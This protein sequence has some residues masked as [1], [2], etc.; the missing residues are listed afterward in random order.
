MGLVISNSEIQKFKDCKRSWYAQYYLQ[1]QPKEQP[2]TGATYLGTKVHAA[3][4][5]YYNPDLKCTPV[6][7]GRLLREMY[8]LDES[9]HPQDSEKLWD[10]YALA[11][12]MVYG[13]FEWL[14][15][16]GADQNL[17]VI[18]VERE[19]VVK[20]NDNISIRGRLDMTVAD[21]H[22]G[23]LLFMD[24]KTC[25]QWLTVDY[26][27]R[28]EQSKFYMMLQRLE[29]PGNSGLWCDGGIFNMLRKV[30]RTGKAVPPFYKRETIRHNTDTL[31]SMYLRTVEAAS[32][33][34]EVRADLDAG[35]DHRQVVY[36]H[37]GKDCVWKC[38]LASGLC[39]MLDDGSDWQGF[40]ENEWKLVDPYARYYEHSYLDKLDQAGIL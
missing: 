6:Q 22:S 33:I 9:A 32:E 20:L 31:N 19:I 23:S 14:A 38:P 30:K 37:P 7:V 24:H 5:A 11:D 2:T 29:N 40:L 12:T 16:T 8:K 21:K 10:E 15:E 18:G 3:L 17:E 36:P 35:L 27:D 39:A 34:A 4:E 28:D 1:R 13:Y 26:L 25:I